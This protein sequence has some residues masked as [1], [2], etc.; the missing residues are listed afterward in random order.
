MTKQHRMGLMVGPLARRASAPA[1]LP[2]QRK[3]DAAC[4]AADLSW[5]TSDDRDAFGRHEGAQGDPYGRFA[6]DPMQNGEPALR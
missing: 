1:V 3:A 6:D 2:E 5:L 4:R